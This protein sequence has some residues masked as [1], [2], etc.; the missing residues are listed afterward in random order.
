MILSDQQMDAVRLG[1]K[2][3][4][5]FEFIDLPCGPQPLPSWGKGLHIDWMDQY[6]NAPNLAIKTTGNVRDW[7]DKRFDKEGSRYMA[8]HPDGRAEVYYHDGAVR[9]QTL[10][11]W[12]GETKEQEVFDAFATTTQQGFGG[13]IIPVQIGPV[14]D[15]PELRGQEVLLRGPWH[16]GAP[17]GY[18]EVAYHYP[19]RDLTGWELKRPWWR[20]T[21]TGGLL[22]SIDLFLRIFAR[23]QP[24]LR[25]VRAHY[26]GR[27]HTEPMKP[28]WDEPKHWVYERQFAARKAARAAQAAS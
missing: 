17:P 20:R 16:G 7:P 26:Y 8:R 25:I 12:N 28:E 14:A 27:M 24:H 11:R 15:R 5:W 19:W 22:L 6:S 4:D 13:S 10:T 3:V 1:S 18:V 21:G 23:Y 2:G 9:M